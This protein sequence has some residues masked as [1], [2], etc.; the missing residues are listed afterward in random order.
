[1]SMKKL[2]AALACLM[3]SI[4][5]LTAAENMEFLSI[6]QLHQ[7]T[8]VSFSI[9]VATRNGDL[10]I[11]APIIVPKKEQLPVLNVQ[12]ID[13]RGR[14]PARLTCRSNHKR[15]ILQVSIVDLLPGIQKLIP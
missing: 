15:I 13:W 10:T 9:S 1:M 11:T 3:L 5:T 4:P 7:T 12:Y 14:N 6:Q 8:P 2:L